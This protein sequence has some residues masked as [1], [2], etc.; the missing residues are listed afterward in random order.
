MAS[1][2]KRVRNGR[3]TYRVRYRDPAG[4]Q[5]SRV[6]ARKADAQRFLSETENAKLKG[7][8]TD[9][10][11]GRVRLEDWLEEWW[12]TTTNL[13][14]STAARDADYIRLYIGS[15]FASTPLAAISQRDVRAWVAE[16]SA[17]GLAPATVQKAYQLLGKV[18]GAA[19]DAGMLAQS[20]CR[21][22]PL[23]K[24]EREEMRFLT[25][26]E[27]ATLADAIAPRYRAL[28]L[29]GAYGGLR[30]GELAGLRRRRVDLLRGTV[31]VA[32]ILT[33]VR[34]EL[35]VGPPKTRAGRRRV[36]L[37]QAVVR[38]LAR[39]LGAPGG[40]DDLVFTAP[41]GG[42]LRV[43]GFRGRVWRPATR[44]ADLDGL[45]I[46]DLR[47]TAVALWIAAGANPKEVSAR[48]GHASVS[49]TLDR[50][51]HL[52]PEADAALRDRL[53]AFYVAGGPTPGG[54]VVE[55]PR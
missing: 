3:V 36:G 40:L 12:A 20:P 32:E 54:T 5:R 55:L 16:L 6:F 29:V 37:P 38:E 48:A 2:Q 18:L 25:P 42:P 11:L 24:V 10:A 27:V 53:D 15:R 51:G 7:T 30:I 13:R 9:P 34:G 43:N 52:F 8:W 39:H 26:A 47:H 45:R 21:R 28:V 35:F 22:V 19:V 1:I 33:E 41:Q 49:F 17:R 4:R 50:Y 31:E 23:P 46:H 44:A 14:P